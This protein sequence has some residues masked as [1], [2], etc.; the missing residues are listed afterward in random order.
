LIKSA[1]TPLSALV[2][3][4]VDIAIAA[5]EITAAAL[6]HI[7]LLLIINNLLLSTD[8]KYFREQANKHY[9]FVLGQHRT[10]IVRQMRSQIF[11]QIVL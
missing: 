5:A 4:A 9:S 8:W 2:Q 7:F 1:E 6:A 10:K 11:R 3:T